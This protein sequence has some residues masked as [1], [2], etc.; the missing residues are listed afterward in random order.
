LAAKEFTSSR[1]F[2]NA[3][4]RSSGVDGWDWAGVWE[5]NLLFLYFF[6]SLSLSALESFC[7]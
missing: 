2:I 5:G 4:A 7:E 1:L 3:A 6:F